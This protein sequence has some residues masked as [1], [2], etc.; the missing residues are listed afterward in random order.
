MLQ[1]ALVGTKGLDSQASLRPLVVPFVP[2]LF[3]SLVQSC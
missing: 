1:W 3:N 2:T